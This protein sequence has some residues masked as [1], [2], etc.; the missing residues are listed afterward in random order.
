MRVAECS[1]LL[2]TFPAIF[3]I[4]RPFISTLR[5]VFTLL[6]V[7][8]VYISRSHN[9]HRLSLEFIIVIIARNSSFRPAHRTYRP[10]PPTMGI[11]IISVRRFGIFWQTNETKS[12][13]FK[14]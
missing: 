4:P 13:I 2:A 5:R 14:I 10:N 7:L 8:S 6:F 3:L 12:I 9:H 1:S 11:N